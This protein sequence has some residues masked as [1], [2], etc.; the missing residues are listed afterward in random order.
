MLEK[1]LI[2]CCYFNYHPK[3]RLIE[4]KMG[5]GPTGKT[6]KVECIVCKKIY[7]RGNNNINPIIILIVIIL[8]L[9]FILFF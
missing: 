6:E 9:L 1:L 5:F 8:F 2:I 4:V 3:I 7:I